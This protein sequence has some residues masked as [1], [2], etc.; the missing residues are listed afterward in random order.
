MSFVYPGFLFALAAISIPIVVHLFNFRRFRKVYFSDIRFLKQ[1]DMQTRSRNQLKHLLVLAARILAVACLVLAFAQPFIPADGNRDTSPLTH[2]TIYVDNSFSM[3]ADGEQGSLLNEARAK[4]LEVATA[5]A[6]GSNLRLLTNDF[7]PRHQ[8][9]MSLEEFKSEVASITPSPAVR[10]MSEVAAR[11]QADDRQGGGQDIFLISDLQRS[12]TDVTATSVDSL[13]NLFILPVAATSVSNLYVDSVWFTGP[14]R[15]PDQPDV[16][17][18]RIRNTSD[19]AVENLT[20][21]LLINGTQR[22]IG[23][24]SLQGR[25]FE[26]VELAF[27]NAGR[28]IQLA[29]V[30]IEDYPIVY[31]NRYL[32]SYSVARTVPVLHIKGED[33]TDA[34][35]RLFKDDTYMAFTE[36]GANSIDFSTFAQQR[37]IV[38]SGVRKPSTGMMQE[39]MRF[40]ANGGHVL[41]VPSA[42]AD[43]TAQNELL[44][45]LGAEPFA[46]M[47]SAAQKVD[48]VN[49]QSALM[50]NV[51]M[52]WGER[53]D[54]PTTNGHFVTSTN[55]KSGREP[56][57]TLANGSPFLSRYPSGKGSVYVLASPLANNMTN[58]HRHALFVPALYNMAL[59]STNS[60][61][62]AETLGDEELIPINGV[63]TEKLV[64]PALQAV[65][66]GERFMPELVVRGDGI[67]IM[68]HGQVRTDG[69]YMLL[70][71][72]DT[73]QSVSFNYNRAE[74][75]LEYYTEKEFTK[76]AENTGIARMEFVTAGLG[77]ISNT[78]EEIHEGKRLW[79]LFLI[80][81]LLFLAMET[82]LLRL[83]K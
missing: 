20:V 77:N 74:S 12:T 15:L 62:S 52:E 23:T 41:V 66:T 75:A 26:Q 4:A 53:I 83:W 29:E 68:V 5:Y 9:S 21:K 78:I 59:N 71:E 81:A 16:L 38:V 3:N 37:L 22:A 40:C 35:T 80:L 48:R 32:I 36:T 44:T 11:A 17:T 67:G 69:H 39:L 13:S 60:G 45:T 64:N 72:K 51:F 54:L 73:V 33:G 27:T 1:V 30:A 19:N 8:R 6:N 42:Q 61:T 10:T 43:R 31:D 49:L 56:L 63:A 46:G 82:L 58:F 25:S 24:V 7:D 18:A 14:V 76:L 34:V 47:D 79:K 2:A 65:E 57:L 50:R 55:A 70:A 28:G